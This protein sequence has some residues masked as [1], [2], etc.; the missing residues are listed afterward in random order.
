MF[1][2]S[3][4]FLVV[5]TVVASLPQELFIGLDELLAQLLR[6]PLRFIRELHWRAPI[7]WRPASRVT[8]YPEYLPPLHFSKEVIARYRAGTAV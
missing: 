1:W 3:Q 4:T 5:V 2:S 6:N 8:R 7:S